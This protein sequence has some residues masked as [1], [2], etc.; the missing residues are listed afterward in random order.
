MAQEYNM[1]VGSFLRFSLESAKRHWLK[2]FGIMIGGILGLALLATIGFK[3]NENLGI[4]LAMLGAIGFSFGL[5]ANVIR[6]ASNQGF[7]IKAFIPEPMVFLNFL[8]GMILLVVAIM[9]GLILLIIPGIIVALMFSLVPFL[10]VDKKMSFIQAFS[11][12]AR[13]TKGHKMDIF[14][15]G[16]VTN[17]VISLLSIPVITLFFTIPMEVFAQVFPYVQLVGL[18]NPQPA[19]P[20]AES[21]QPAPEGA[22]T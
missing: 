16:L 8:V 22:A 19:A 11:E 20:A 3:I 9:I 6:L 13:L 14:I 18:S 4:L 21:A 2:F 5:F 10:I 1:E 7:S 15:G 17:L 12:S